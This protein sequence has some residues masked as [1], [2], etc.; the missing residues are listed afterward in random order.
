MHVYYDFSTASAQVSMSSLYEYKLETEQ[1]NISVPENKSILRESSWYLWS[2]NRA[3][4][5]PKIIL[6]PHLGDAS[7]RLKNR[8]LQD[9]AV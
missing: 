3:H 5:P 4:V 1:S 6:C 8:A 2:L 7:P 9:V